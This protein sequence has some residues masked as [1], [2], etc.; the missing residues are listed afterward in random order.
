MSDGAF[1]RST[2][3]VAK[4]WPEEEV[5]GDFDG[6]MESDSDLETQLLSVCG[7][8][9]SSLC[10]EVCYVLFWLQGGHCL[11]CAESCK[12]RS[13]LKVFS[14]LKIFVMRASFGP[15]GLSVAMMR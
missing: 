3:S 11:S 4:L 12:S 13:F 14:G 2:L 6:V 7:A 5:L 9:G 1:Q 15:W 10:E 8:T